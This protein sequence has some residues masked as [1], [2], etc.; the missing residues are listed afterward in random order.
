MKNTITTHPPKL[1]PY[2]AS[3]AGHDGY[4]F[5][6]QGYK[7]KR[8]NVDVDDNVEFDNIINSQD[9][10]K[11]RNKNRNENTKKGTKV[12]ASRSTRLSNRNNNQKKN[13]KLWTKN[14]RIK[15]NNRV[16]GGYVNELRRDRE[17]NRNINSNRNEN[18]NRNKSIDFE[19]KSEVPHECGYNNCITTQ[20]LKPKS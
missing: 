6:H 1:Y 12:Q 3:F 2:Q 8:V 15:W 13:F 9:H 16:P 7:W 20:H 14:K 18:R 4:L 10:N 19:I 11:N 17:R 5:K